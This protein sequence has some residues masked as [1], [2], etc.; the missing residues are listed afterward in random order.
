MLLQGA[1]HGDVLPSEIVG[2]IEDE[3]HP[4]MLLQ[5]LLLQPK[6]CENKC[7]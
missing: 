4:E 1:A 2:Q 3:Q 6:S 5:V 7:W